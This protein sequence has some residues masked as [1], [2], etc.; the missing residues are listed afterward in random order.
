LYIRKMSMRTILLAATAMVAFAANSLFCRLALADD[1][2]DAASFTGI[3]LASGTLVMLLLC[4]SVTQP[5]NLNGNWISGLA[6]F[7]YAMLFSLAYTGLSAAT[8]ALLL[9]GAVQATM[10]GYGL[11]AGERICMI[12][13]GGAILAVAGLVYLMLP[14]LAAPPFAESAMMLSAGIAWGIYSLRG[15]RATSPRF[16]TAG[17]FL[18]ALPFV[19]PAYLFALRDLHWDYMGIIYALSS[20]TLASGIGYAIWY[21]VLPSLPAT[22]AA[23]LQL[24]VPILAAFGGVMFVGESFT[25]RLAY[26][27]MSILGGV[28][29]FILNRPGKTGADLK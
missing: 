10:I 16:A 7:C 14:G 22:S 11:F 19:V 27:A 25:A 2:I 21:A 23:M 24:S 15:R 1:H 12:Q 29:I 8:G 9:F 20:G 13:A 18:R 6:L 5:G 3:R 4:K 17:N 28:G 26:A